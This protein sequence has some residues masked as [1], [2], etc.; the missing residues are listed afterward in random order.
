MQCSMRLYLCK[1][2]QPSIA[3]L[4]PFL[5]VSSLNSAAPR[6]AALFLPTLGGRVLRLFSTVHRTWQMM[7]HRNRTIRSLETG[8]RQGAPSCC[9]SGAGGRGAAMFA[10]GKPTG[11][12]A[13]R[14]GIPLPLACSPLPHNGH[15]A[16]DKKEGRPIA[17]APE[18]PREETHVT[19]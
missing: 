3:G 4:L 17:G 11:R 14:W 19:F 2:Q 16:H 15:R 1:R 18:L 9:K 5:D 10:A 7:V 13:M 8:H 6:G 12:A